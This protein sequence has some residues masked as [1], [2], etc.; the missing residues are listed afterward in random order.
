[1]TPSFAILLVGL[2]IVGGGLS[3]LLGIGGGL[4]IIPL[5][6]YVPAG[7]G[8][9]VVDIRTASAVAVMQ[10][11]A[12]T[13]SG[14]LAHGRQ[15]RVFVGLAV[16]MSVGSV[17]G[18]LLGGIVSAYVPG[19]V[20]LVVTALL[21]T[22]AA[23]LMFV[24][25]PTEAAGPSSFPPFNP[26]LAILAG[27]VVGLVIGMNGAGAFLMVPMLIY[28]FK[29]PTRVALATVLAVGVP[30]ALAAAAGKIATGQVPL[31]PSLAVI[32]GAIPGAQLGSIVSARTP[33]RVLRWA[34]GL[35]VFVIAAGM[36]W[37]VF[38]SGAPA[39]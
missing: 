19:E 37:D 35:L 4:V 18:A 28:L 39:G 26:I 33:I 24:P 12:A 38:N 15:R 36:W 31:W 16:T 25:R 29:I 10:V 32:L 6:L 3:G 5:L 1:M 14:T 11:V 2:G 17:A 22:V 30:T 7:L 34:Y 8:L 13:L 21:A 23:A 20:L 27:L 9:A